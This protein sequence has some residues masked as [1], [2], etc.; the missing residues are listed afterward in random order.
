MLRDE[1]MQHHRSRAHPPLS[2]PH[3][4]VAGGP[5]QVASSDIT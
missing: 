5:W 2:R 1:H 3:D 4:H